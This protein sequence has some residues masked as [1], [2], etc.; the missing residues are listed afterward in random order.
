MLVVQR[1]EFSEPFP[2]YPSKAYRGYSTTCIPDLDGLW[3]ASKDISDLACMLPERTRAS[4]FLTVTH[5]LYQVSYRQILGRE[6]SVSMT[7][8]S[9]G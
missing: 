6:K 2:F 7:F 8:S 3:M 5:G 4:Q 9:I 1:F